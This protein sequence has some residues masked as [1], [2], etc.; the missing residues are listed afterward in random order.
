[1]VAENVGVE[2]SRAEYLENLWWLMHH[3]DSPDRAT[4]ALTSYYDD[5]GTDD[6]SPITA[7]GGPVMSRDA[8][9]AFDRRWSQLLD[10]YRVPQPLH[11]TDFV[12]PYGK[13]VGMHKEMKIALFSEA[14][15]IINDHKLF[16]VSIGIPQA[17]F[18]LTLPK[19]VR[20]HLLSPYAL[21]FFCAVLITQGVCKNS[22]MARCEV[23]SYLVDDGSSCKSQL[24]DA[25][26]WIVNSEKSKGQP[27]NTGAMAFDTDDRVSALQAADMI[28]WSARRREIDGQLKDEFEPLA[29]VLAQE[30]RHQHISIP[31]KG[32]EAWAKPIINWIFQTGEV[33]S[34]EDFLR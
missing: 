18:K 21:A 30:G 3:S 22:V 24:K 11:M 25:H 6:G 13:H 19:D 9:I 27:R 29:A 7:I 1:M 12:R 31:L 33:P 23:I 16:S 5:S 10:L 8:F 20:K 2:R 15:G 14:A 26:T 32:I 17:D 4:M 28:A 34:F